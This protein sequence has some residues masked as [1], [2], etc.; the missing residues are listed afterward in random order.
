MSISAEGEHTIPRNRDEDSEYARN[1]LR[2]D[3]YELFDMVRD[4]LNH[5][6]IEPIESIAYDI[7][8]TVDELCRWVIKFSEKGRKRQQY[9]SKAFAPLAQPRGATREG[10]EQSDDMRR[11]KIAQ[12]ARDGARA[13]LAASSGPQHDGGSR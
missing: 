11:Q 8:V 9:Q 2:P 10:W 12:R 6:P 13:A 4:R 7:G 1:I 5:R 3:N